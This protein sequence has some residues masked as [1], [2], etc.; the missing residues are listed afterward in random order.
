VKWA[1]VRDLGAIAKSIPPD[2]E[3]YIELP[4]DALDDATLDTIAGSGARAKLRLG[5]LVPEAFPSTEAVACALA[6]L[7]RHGLAFKATAGLHHP[8]RARHR[9][10]YTADSPTGLMHGFVNLACAAALIHFGGD[11]PAAQAILE[12]QDSGAWHRSRDEIRWRSERWS[13]D[14]LSETRL[15][16]FISF[17]SCSLEEPICDLEALGWC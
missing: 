17:G 4:I 10:T 14:Q 8:V 7:G 3:R 11:A 5:G 6:V 15:Q 1:A 9:L 13:A 16:F 12:E 2:L